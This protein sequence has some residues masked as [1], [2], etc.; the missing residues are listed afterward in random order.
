[1]GG[2]LLEGRSFRT[3]GIGRGERDVRGI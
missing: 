2:E 3:R 1:L